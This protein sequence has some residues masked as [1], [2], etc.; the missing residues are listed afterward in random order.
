MDLKQISILIYL[1]FLALFALGWWADFSPSASWQNFGSYLSLGTGIF[2]SAIVIWALLTDRLNI[3][4]GRG[5]KY[6]GVVFV[7]IFVFPVIWLATVHGGGFISTQISYEIKESTST[8]TK[9]P[10]NSR[11]RC[12]Y[13]LE[14]PFTYDAFPSY[15]CISSE[16]YETLSSRTNLTLEIKENWFGTSIIGIRN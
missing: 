6:L 1:L 12:N 11:R 10:R 5:R 14:G 7:P 3:K 9:G 15:Y 4:A 2:V 16:V 8:A 13:Y